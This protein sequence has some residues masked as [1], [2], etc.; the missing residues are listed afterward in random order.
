MPATIRD[1]AKR[2]G[3]GVGT[4]SRVLNNHPSVRESTRRRVEEAIAALNYRPNT[5]ARQLSS[6]K[7]ANIGV[8]A[9][10]FIRPSSVERLRGV[11]TVLVERQYDL[12]LY[13]VETKK[14]RDELFQTLPRGDMF[15]GLLVF[16]LS[17]NDDEAERLRHAAVPVVLV[18]AFHPALSRV[19]IDDIEGGYM[20]TKHLIDLGHTRI[21]YISDILES[22]FEFVG[23][24]AQRYQGYRRAL[25]EAGIEFRPEY[26]LQDQHGAPQAQA[27]THR[28]LSLAEPPTAI[29]AA[30]DTQAIGVLRAAKERNVAVP[31][32]LSVMGF[33]DIEVAE[34]L[35]LTTIHQPLFTSGVEGAEL[36][37]RYIEN[38]D[39]LRHE[40]KEVL[41]PLRLIQRQTTAPPPSHTTR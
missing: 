28:L 39:E 1:V 27:M 6:G 24:S 21:A 16:T 9:P 13:N 15:D 31:E 20:A 23:A 25:H 37:F 19:V 17:P 8:V 7:T 36:L 29:F 5:I 22:P 40:V 12:I 4:V 33:D 34:Y 18:D 30:S 32:Q 26:Y 2:A 3:V 10:F 11:E 38:P 35:N 14:K 41:L